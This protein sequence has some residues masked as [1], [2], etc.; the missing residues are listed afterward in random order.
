KK[1][2]EELFHR[3][4]DTYLNRVES[5]EVQ[6]PDQISVIL[7]AFVIGDIAVGGI[8]FEV[9]AESGLQLKQQNTFKNSFTFGIA[10]GY[11]GYLPTPRQHKKGGYETW[12]TSNKVET[13]ASDIIKEELLEMF[14]S[15][16][17]LHN[18]NN[19]NTKK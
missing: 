17:Y 16:K 18:I 11:W 4:E 7:Q 19:L 14:R 1:K 15:M 8:P 13:G 10:N 5:H 6:Y 3:L 2:G 12:L 9:F